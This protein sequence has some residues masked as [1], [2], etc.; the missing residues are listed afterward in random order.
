I[1]LG[2]AVDFIQQIGINKVSERG[3]ELATFFKKELIKNEQIEL[4][5]PLNS[6]NTGSIVTF[7]IKNKDNQKFETALRKKYHYFVR[8]IYENNL[9]ALRVSCSI[10]NTESDLKNLLKIINIV[11]V[12]SN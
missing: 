9:D 5:T 2:A 12:E 10:Y 4:V 8:S 7:R 11:C 6:S 1:G 3:N